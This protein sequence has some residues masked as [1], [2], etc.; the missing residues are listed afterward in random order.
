MTDETKN[1]KE[2]LDMY[3]ITLQQIPDKNL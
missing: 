1:S 2:A 3:S